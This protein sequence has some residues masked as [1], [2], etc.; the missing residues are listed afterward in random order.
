MTESQFAHITDG[1]DI[2]A[3]L[4]GGV[5]AI[6]NFDGVHRGHR[7]VLGRARD[8]ARQR[9]VPALAVTFEPHP[10]SYFS[11]D[12][13]LF[14]LTP[15]EAKAELIEALGLDA[16]VEIAFDAALAATSAED[17]VDRIL[18]GR[19]G[20]AAVVVGFDFHFGKGRAGSPEVLASLGHDRGF[21]VVVVAKAGDGD[22]GWSSS[23]A[24]EALADGRVEDAAAILG[25]RWFV[26]GE[27]VH[28]EK[29]GRELGFP[30]ANMRLP[31]DCAL[32]HGVYAVRMRVGAA[33]HDGVA[34]YGRRPQFDNGAALLETYLF[35][36]SLD[37]YGATVEVE[38]FDFIRPEARFSSVE[39]LIARMH[40]DAAVAR[41]MLGG[42]GDAPDGRAASAPA[43]VSG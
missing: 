5:V 11:P 32:R 42:A 12:Q 39:E 10:R 34:S 19:L 27:V 21:D 30:T 9:R 43:R 22:A 33:T 15:P 13:P 23:A 6:G 31:A 37:L 14:R 38:F 40:E 20:A 8:I 4:R 35:D 28:G 16:M 25:Y 26:R 1:R 17:F 29:R 36:A 3:R 24:R 2:P 18:V 7:A 41:R